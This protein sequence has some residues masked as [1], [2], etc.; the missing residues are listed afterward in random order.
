M[1]EPDGGEH[2]VVLQV[3]T[4]KQ[5]ADVGVGRERPEPRRQ[6][7]EAAGRDVS[8]SQQIVLASRGEA[9]ISE[10][11]ERGPFRLSDV[12]LDARGDV[13]DTGG[14]SIHEPRRGELRVGGCA[15]EEVLSGGAAER[16]DL[17]VAGA[18]Q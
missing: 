11:R 2:G 9:N 15:A 14:G 3:A 1:I 16:N 10:D 17:R 8:R 12:D 13:T 4:P 7:A 18:A 6:D 5:V